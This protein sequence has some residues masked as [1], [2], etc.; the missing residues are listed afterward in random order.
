MFPDL[1]ITC[2]SIQASL[3]SKSQ[4]VCKVCTSHMT[5]CLLEVTL[6]ACH[7]D[8]IKLPCSCLDPTQ[9]AQRPT[10]GSKQRL[11]T[12]ECPAPTNWQTDQVCRIK[13]QQDKR[14]QTRCINRQ[15]H[16][17]Q[18]G[19]FLGRQY[20]HTVGATCCMLA[21]ELLTHSLFCP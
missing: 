5:S 4:Q 18:A 2:Y 1:V 14:A 3:G 15:L 10:A 19:R 9:L 13:Q 11:D 17:G 6:T 16:P 20:A 8:R 12:A 21:E 7:S